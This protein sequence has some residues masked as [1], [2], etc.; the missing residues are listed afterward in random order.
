MRAETIIVRR[1]DGVGMSLEVE[2][3]REQEFD[4]F[5]VFREAFGF[6]PNLLRA[7]TRC[8]ARSQR[9]RNSKKRCAFRDG[10]I[11]RIH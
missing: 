2:A 1:A 4:P 7:Q 9:T 5:I 3:R 8:L 10:A 11:S 6:I